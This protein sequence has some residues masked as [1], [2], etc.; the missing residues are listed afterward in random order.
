MKKLFILLAIFILVAGFG[1]AQIMDAGAAGGTTAA[2]N[3]ADVP[4]LPKPEIFD[5]EISGAYPVH[6]TNGK[7]DDS[8]YGA[9]LTN[10][11]NLDKTVT[12]NTAIGIGLLWNFGRKVGLTIDMDFFYA[13][14]EQGFSEAT[15]NAVSLFGANVLIGPVFFLYNS[16]FLRIPLT[17]GAHMYY[18]FDEIWEPLLGSGTDGVW[19]QRK[20]FQVG[21]G[22]SLGVQFHFNNNVYIFS[23]TTVGIDILR[24]H[25]I[26]VLGIVKNDEKDMGVSWTVKPALGLGIKF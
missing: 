13:A 3:G 12:A 10:N 17:I 16:S 5:L 7:H 6:W 23:K 8:F 2:A 25:D 24:W 15:S 21:P 18:Y 14:R 1:F 19:I 22:I 11:P 9:L 4:A 26:E 20:D